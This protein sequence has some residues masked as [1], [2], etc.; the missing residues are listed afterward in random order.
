MDYCEEHETLKSYTL[1]VQE[2]SARLITKILMDSVL[3]RALKLNFAS[4]KSC[5]EMCGREDAGLQP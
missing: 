5:K 3:T 1:D 2:K 4:N